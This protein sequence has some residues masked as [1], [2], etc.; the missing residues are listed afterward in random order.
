M[1]GIRGEP[2][3]HLI[4]VSDLLMS[5]HDESIRRRNPCLHQGE[6]FKTQLY[7]T[8]VAATPLAPQ[9]SSKEAYYRDI[10]PH[11]DIAF[12]VSA[13]NSI[14]DTAL[15]F[16][17]SSSWIRNSQ[18]SRQMLFT[19]ARQY[20]SA[21]RNTPFFHSHALPFYIL[22]TLW[23]IVVTRLWVL[24][25]FMLPMSWRRAMIEDSGSESYR[26]KCFLNIDVDYETAEVPLSNVDETDEE[27]TE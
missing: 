2:S 25:A 9:S 11:Q 24:L 20:Q 18:W 15:Q 21:I 22:P 7:Q 13:V 6:S 3:L 27:D 5:V 26:L 14:I 19:W 4:S 17:F 23:I 16:P 8:K 12:T 10:I 1:L